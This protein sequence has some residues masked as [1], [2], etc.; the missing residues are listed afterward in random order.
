[1]DVLKRL[2]SEDGFSLV[3]LSVVLVNF[4]I[5]LALA[6]PAFLGAVHRTQDQSAKASVRTA[7]T[8]GRIVYASEADYTAATVTELQGVD[9]SILWVDEITTS[10]EPTTV[11]RDTAGG[12]LTLA[13]Y[14]NAGN[15]FF[16]LDDP[17]GAPQF[18]S[19]IAV[20]P[21]D[22]YASNS[23]AVTFGPSW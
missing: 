8:A 2:R 20:A 15:C 18:G 16:L 6:T 3:E 14:S 23:G 1:M 4:G 9:G 12:L 11:S 10:I 22:C 5:L 17:D 7:L 13:A 21:A 19:L